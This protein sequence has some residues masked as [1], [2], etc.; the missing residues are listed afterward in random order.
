MRRLRFVGLAEDGVHL[1]VSTDDDE[2]YLLPVDDEL[3]RAVRGLAGQQQLQPP[4]ATGLRPRDIQV[5]VRAGASAEQLAAESG[6]SIERVMRFA[7]PVLAERSQVVQQA[8]HARIRRDPEAP[9]L[10]EVVDP[11]LAARG[12]DPAAVHWDSWKRDDGTW[13]VVA[14]WGLADRA[15]TATWMYELSTRVLVA[16]DD[17]AQH[18]AG[19]DERPFAGRLTPVTPLAAAAAR[20]AAYGEHPTEPIPSVAELVPPRPDRR[21][22]D[23]DDDEPDESGRRR[24]RVPSW[25]EILL[26]P[27]RRP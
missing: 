3:R 20:A 26:G 8:R 7:Y 10:A 25:D 27:R 15:R 21:P 4:S 18:L 23:D 19:D 22:A 11:R 24:V 2:C 6:M 17:L 14:S 5:R 1:V 13:V 9:T 12:V 16:E